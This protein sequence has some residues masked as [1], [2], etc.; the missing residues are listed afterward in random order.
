VLSILRP[1]GTPMRA[2][3]QPPD[4][5]A[6]PGPAHTRRRAGRL[7]S[8]LQLWRSLPKVG[9][10]PA[11][12]P[13]E[14]NQGQLLEG[15]ASA[16]MLCRDRE[17]MQHA[18]YYALRPCSA[19]VALLCCSRSTLSAI[20]SMYA[21]AAP[22]NTCM[23]TLMLCPCEVSGGFHRLASQNKSSMSLVWFEVYS[24]AFLRIRGLLIAHA[25]VHSQFGRRTS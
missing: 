19:M 2:H 4:S 10:A 12:I 13:K 8:Q 3:K 18:C 7:R 20:V 22:H 24:I 6:L 11:A 16:S 1:Q 25:C 17:A 21:C 14:K 9:P 15:C 5:R 23:L